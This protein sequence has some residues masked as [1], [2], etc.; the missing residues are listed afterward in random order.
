MRKPLQGADAYGNRG[1][2]RALDPA[3]KSYNI[4]FY[5]KKSHGRIVVNVEDFMMKMHDQIIVIDRIEA[6]GYM[7]IRTGLAT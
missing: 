1:C 2:I 6:F 7:Y 5:K 4:Q 3:L